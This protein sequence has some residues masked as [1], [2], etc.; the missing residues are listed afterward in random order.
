MTLTGP[1]PDFRLD[2]RPFMPQGDGAQR[3]LDDVPV[4][5]LFPSPP[6]SPTTSG[7]VQPEGALGDW[8]DC[9]VELALTLIMF[10]TPRARD[11]GGVMSRVTHTSSLAQAEVCRGS[12]S[13]R[14]AATLATRSFRGTR[15]WHGCSQSHGICNRRLFCS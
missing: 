11:E 13:R 9:N 6:L 1:K 2:R 12:S 10:R 8:Q 7:A 3:S 5:E 14:C 15:F 4:R